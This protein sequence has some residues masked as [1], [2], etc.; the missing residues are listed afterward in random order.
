MVWHPAH[1]T[2][3]RLGRGKC[4]PELDARVMG[5]ALAGNAED[6]IADREFAISG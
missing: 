4:L 5:K 2:P 3:S 1:E 6:H